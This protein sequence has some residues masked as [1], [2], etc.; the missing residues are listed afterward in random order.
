LLLQTGGYNEEDIYLYGGITFEK[1]PD[2]Q[3][4]MENV[5]L[6]TLLKTQRFAMIYKASVYNKGKPK[7]CVAKTLKGQSLVLLCVTIFS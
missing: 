2:W 1:Q 6:E 5:T 7:E 3:Y 4:S